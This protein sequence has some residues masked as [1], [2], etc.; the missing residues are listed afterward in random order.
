MMS[1]INASASEE[2]KVTSIGMVSSPPHCSMPI[3]STATTTANMASRRAQIASCEGGSSN[4]RRR[5]RAIDMVV[6]PNFRS[7][8]PNRVSIIAEKPRL[9]TLDARPGRRFCRL[10]PRRNRR[11]TL[12]PLN[13][14]PLGT[15]QSAFGTH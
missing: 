4:I 5:V 13:K 3:A 6:T 8:V 10:G 14:G 9:F 12:V 2:P 11:K 1:A 15:R 7:P